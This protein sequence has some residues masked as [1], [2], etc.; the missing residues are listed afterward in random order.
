MT[1]TKEDKAAI[2][3]PTVVGPKTLDEL[4]TLYDAQVAGKLKLIGM[5]FLGGWCN[6]DY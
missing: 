5:R 6:C 4:V 3:A 2:M 1:L